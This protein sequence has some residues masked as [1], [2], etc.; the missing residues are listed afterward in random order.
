MHKLPRVLILFCILRTI[1]KKICM[2]NS[3]LLNRRNI[4]IN[5]EMNCTDVSLGLLLL[6]LCNLGSIHGHFI[7]FTARFLF[8][9]VFLHKAKQGRVTVCNS[10]ISPASNNSAPIHISSPRHIIGI[11]MCFLWEMFLKV[12]GS[13]QS[14]LRSGTSITTC[15]VVKANMD[16]S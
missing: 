3:I 7:L 16:L 11:A 10:Q 5:I 4:G 14:D 15:C 1:F 2:R 13:G 9:V 12:F 8:C 6:F